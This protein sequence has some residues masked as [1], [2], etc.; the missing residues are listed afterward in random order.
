MPIDNTAGAAAGA[1]ERSEEGDSI[2]V[3]ESQNQ[4]QK[5]KKKRGKEDDRKEFRAGNCN[6]CNRQ[7][8]IDAHLPICKG[9]KVEDVFTTCFRRLNFFSFSFLGG[10]GETR[11]GG[12]SLV[13]FLRWVSFSFFF[14]YS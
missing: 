4:N 2:S 5:K 12:Q 9:A 13:Y 14:S 7:Y 11:F 10:F 3:G 1:S 8:C 6:D